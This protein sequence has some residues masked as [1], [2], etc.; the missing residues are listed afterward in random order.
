MATLRPCRLGPSWPAPVDTAG[1]PG[2]P[3]RTRHRAV[4]TAR[5]S[6]LDSWVLTPG[7]RLVGD[8][9]S[10]SGNSYSQEGCR[11]LADGRNGLCLP[12]VF[13]QLPRGTRTNPFRTR[14]LGLRVLSPGRGRT[15][16][17][18]DF[19]GDGSSVIS[20]LHQRAQA[21]LP[22]RFHSR[23]GLRPDREL[24]VHRGIAVGRSF[25]RLVHNPGPRYRVNPWPRGVDCSRWYGDRVDGDRQ[26]VEGQALL[27]GQVHGDIRDRH[28]RGRRDRH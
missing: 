14:P 15:I 19:Q 13:V 6:D 10:A 4:P 17:R 24:P 3:S 2:R 9:R 26:G 1:L 22:G 23:P 8:F 20:A 11:G 28:R 27:E 5:D 21:R 16:V 25:R 18:G 12:C 7:P